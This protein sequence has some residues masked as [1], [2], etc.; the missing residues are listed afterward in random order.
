MANISVDEDG[1]EAAAVSYADIVA[2]DVPPGAEQPQYIEFNCNRPFVY[3]ISDSRT[4]A[5][6]TL[7]CYR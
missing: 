1:T 5:I 4:G 2:I 7:G 6:L 3:A